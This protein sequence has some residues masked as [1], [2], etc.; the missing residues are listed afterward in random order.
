MTTPMRTPVK[1][2]RL[3][4]TD[5]EAAQELVARDAIAFII[6][7]VLDQQITVQK[8]FAGPLELQRRLGTLDAREIVAIPLEELEAAFAEKPSIH[9]YP[10]SM[11]RRVRDALQTIV[12]QYDG[13]P[14]P[15][16]NDAADYD[17]FLKRLGAVAGFGPLKVLGVGA[18]LA[19]QFGLPFTGWEDKLPP[20]GS[21]SEV[22]KLEDLLAYQARKGEFK[23]ARKAER[24]AAKA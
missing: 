20:Y 11:A 23:A 4:F 18:L 7:W 3:A 1:P 16:W 13:D 6:G 21:L 9:R 19:R 12:D 15:I 5:D 17:D 2:D 24:A 14:N 22:R 10:N 8:A